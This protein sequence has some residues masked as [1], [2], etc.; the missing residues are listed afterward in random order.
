MS[1]NLDMD[2]DLDL[3]IIWIQ[4]ES[5]QQER[6]ADETTRKRGGTSEKNKPH[7]RGILIRFPIHRAL[8]HLSQGLQNTPRLAEAGNRSAEEWS[9]VERKSGSLGYH[10]ALSVRIKRWICK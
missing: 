2:L 8:A 4:T 3:K 1:L 5:R 6:V 7:S 10:E 9:R